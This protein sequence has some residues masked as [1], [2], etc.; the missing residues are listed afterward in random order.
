MSRNV[1]I[2]NPTLHPNAKKTLEELGFS[3]FIASDPSEDALIAQI[4]EHQIVGMFVRIE[5]ITGK[6]FDSCPSL[7]IVV[8][9]GIGVDNIDVAAATRNGVQVAN[10]SLG[11]LAV[12]EHTMAFLLAL[13]RD[14]RRNDITTRAGQWLSFNQPSFNSVPIMGSKLLIVGTGN[15]GRQVAKRA[16]GMGME[17]LGFDPYLSRERMAE[18]GIRKV[19]TLEEG[20]AEADFV[21]VHMPL[22]DQ[23]RGMFSTQQFAQMKDSAF[24][25]NVGRGPIVDEKALYEALKNHEIAGAALDVFEQEPTPAD[26]PLFTLDNILFSAHVAGT[27]KTLMADQAI[28]GAQSIAEAID[29]QGL[30]ALNVVNERQLQAQKP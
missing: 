12:A 20:L 9:N 13:G 11:A 18:A 25:V 15:I 22:T 8:E 2:T 10:L 30:Y 29:R 26:N 24:F 6:I 21:T 14:L 23:T 28:L 3:V 19:E 1:L 4:N 7:R 16:A 17:L 5:K 27:H